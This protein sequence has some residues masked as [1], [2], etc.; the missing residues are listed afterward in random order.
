M[1]LVELM[2][3]IE[4]K[5]LTNDIYKMIIHGKNVKLMNKPG[6]FVAIKIDDESLI[7]RRPISISEIDKKNNYFTI[8]Y[9]VVGKGTELLINKKPGDNINIFGPLGN[10]FNI[11]NINKDKTVLIVGG[12][13]GIPPLYELAKGLKKKNIKVITVLGFNS[14][15]DIFYE[16]EFKELNETYISTIDGSYGYK[17]NVIDLIDS[18]NIN[19]DYIYACGPKG[20]LK[21]IDDKY[22]NIKKGYLSLEEKMAC[23]VGACTGCICKISGKDEYKRVCKDGPIFALGEM[24][25]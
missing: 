16:K 25:L 15:Q 18:K 2:K 14:H 17:G 13:I 3:V 20:M 8:I 1:K 19:F 12:G 23:G 10:G 21:A 9:R 24:E 5:A 4:N 6:Q 7:L 22:R 11:D